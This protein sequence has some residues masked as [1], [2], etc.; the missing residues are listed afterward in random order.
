[1]IAPQIGSPRCLHSRLASLERVRQIP[2]IVAGDRAFVER[3]L[4]A[5]LAADAVGYSR[6][7]REDEPGRSSCRTNTAQK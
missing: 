1:M 7:M 3:S 2:C 5:I 4:A 6:V